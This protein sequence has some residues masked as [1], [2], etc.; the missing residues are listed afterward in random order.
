MDGFY[1]MAEVFEDL[2]DPRILI[3]ACVRFSAEAW[4]P[5][6]SGAPGVAKAT[7]FKAN[8]RSFGRL[9]FQALTFVSEPRF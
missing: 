2:D 3:I 4:E 8:P 9:R 1:E 6:S 5:G 7:R